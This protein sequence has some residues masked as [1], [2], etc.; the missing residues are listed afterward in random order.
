MRKTWWLLGLG[1]AVLVW[2]GCVSIDQNVPVYAPGQVEPY[3]RS[4]L[5]VCEPH[6]LPHRLIQATTSMPSSMTAVGSALV[7]NQAGFDIWWGMI[8]PQLDPTMALTSNGE[9]L[10]DWA[11]QTVYF[12]V[13]PVTNTCQKAWPYGDGMNT[14]CYTITVSD[15]I[16]TEGPPCDPQTP[17]QVPVYV[18]I[19][20]NT[21]L[22]LVFKWITPTPM[23][24]P[25]PG[26][27]ATETP[28][29][30]VTPTAT[31]T[32]TPT[33]LPKHKK[34]HVQTPV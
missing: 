2:A 18:Y 30:T 3:G 25:P 1:A 27:A 7:N 15:Y 6:S 34:H 31:P 9:P 13:L 33:P 23:P 22:P 17:A 29:P 19:Y 10:I 14:D 16:D 20:P 21:N 26:P 24:S 12:V 11:T 32:A 5:D 8:N 28:T 4:P